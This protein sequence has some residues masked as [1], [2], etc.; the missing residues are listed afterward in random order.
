MLIRGW[1]LSRLFQD[2]AAGAGEGAA[3]GGE[4]AAQESKSEYSVTDPGYT[5]DDVADESGDELA[6][7]KAE[8]KTNKTP[9]DD[10]SADAGDKADE[11]SEAKAKP[12]GESVESE[13]DF[14]EALLDRAVALGYT[15]Q[16]IKSFRSEKTLVKEIERVERL[17]QRMA[18]RQAP[19]QETPPE[20]TPEAIAEP[21]WQQMIE[22]GLDPDDVAFKQQ[23]WNRTTAAEQRAERLEQ[24]ENQRDST[25]FFNNFD[26]KIGGLGDEYQD[27]IGKGTIAQ[28]RSSAPDS[29]AQI[30]KNRQKVMNE[31]VGFRDLMLARGEQLPPDD[32][33]IEKAVHSAFWKQT[34]TLARKELTTDIKKSA[35]QAL[36]RPR[37]TGRQNLTGAAAAADKEAAFWKGHPD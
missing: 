12:T 34:K 13:D 36:S 14:S 29:V 11:P 25:A 31:F 7:L 9:A 16:D 8:N 1:E 32:E 37:S 23:L 6:A 3:V 5:Q 35:S 22:D 4:H 17:Q 15:V 21:D 2:E 19:A 28:I 26:A 30:A 18:S 27:L 10:E 24:R 20:K 33:L